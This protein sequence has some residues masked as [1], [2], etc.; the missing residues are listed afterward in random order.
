LNTHA[1]AATP[2]STSE[3]TLQIYAVGHDTLLDR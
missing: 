1:A 2:T 3:L